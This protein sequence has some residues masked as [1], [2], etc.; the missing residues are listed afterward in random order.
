MA[1][2]QSEVDERT[3]LAGSNKFEMLMF[4]LGKDKAL[5]QS[6]LFGINVF[7]IREIMAMPA[8]TPVVGADRCS[9]GVVNLRGQVIP[10]FDLPH[11]VGC[12]PETGLNILLVTEYGRTTQAFAVESVED[13]ARLDWKQVIPAEASGNVKSLVTSFARL[14]DDGSGQQRLAQVLDVEAIVQM[15]T[16]E[17]E[18]H[19]VEGKQLGAKVRMQGE[20]IV[21]AA[22]DS[23]VARALLEQELKALGASYELVK[24][25]RE[26]WE[27]LNALAEV[28]EAENKSIHDK[29]GLVLTD[30]EMPEMDGFTLTR[31]IKHDARF[32][33]VPVLIHSSLSGTTNEDL[34]RKVGANGYVA[35]FEATEL[36]NAIRSALGSSPGAAG[37]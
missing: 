5:G 24:S 30:L 13:I 28:A 16:P 15:V 36:A 12:T 3:N 4:R 19:T 10:V 27:R 8:I 23:F 17:A 31:N 11:I 18:R 25:G 33:G 34:V 37:A 29:V 20:A 21:L 22:D 35:K 2:P 26:A 1:K 14:D 6:E 9:L 7:K 32:A